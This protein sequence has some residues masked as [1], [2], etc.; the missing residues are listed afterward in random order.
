MDTQT[1][2]TLWVF[3]SMFSVVLHSCESQTNRILSVSYVSIYL[4]TPTVS[5]VGTAIEHLSTAKGHN[6]I[7]SN[8]L[9]CAGSAFLQSV[10]RSNKQVNFTLFPSYSLLLDE[11]RPIATSSVGSKTSSK[12][13]LVTNF[14]NLKLFDYMLLPCYEKWLNLSHNQ[15]AHRPF[16]ECLIAVTI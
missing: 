14:S 7:H 6:N 12:K 15:L 3:L 11:L 9:I 13:R 5:D 10:V 2:T 8:R 4:F 1:L 16:I